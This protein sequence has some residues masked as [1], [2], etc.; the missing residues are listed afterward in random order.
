[1][2]AGYTPISDFALARYNPEG[3]LDTTFGA[4]RGIVTTNISDND[5]FNDV[6]I[7]A[8]GKI[9]AAGWSDINLGDF[10]LARYLSN[11]SG[12]VLLL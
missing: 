9:V 10:V 3:I 2:V 5:F 7:Q 1:M 8:D 12:P 6:I 11:S 4:A